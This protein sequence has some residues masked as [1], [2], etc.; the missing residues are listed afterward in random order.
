VSR[1]DELMVLSFVARPRGSY[2]LA[3]ANISS[4]AV[5]GLGAAAFAPTP[6]PLLAVWK[7]IAREC[8][9]NLSLRSNESRTEPLLELIPELGQLSGAGSVESAARLG[10]NK[11]SR[12]NCARQ[13][14]ATASV[15]PRFRSESRWPHASGSTYVNTDLKIA[16]S[17][18]GQYPWSGW[19]ACAG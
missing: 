17:D 12:L 8:R 1:V 13:L 2:R 9:M 4:S 3:A 7:S 6:E 11:I 18:C 15:L 5:T 14:A 16:D 10:R 19:I